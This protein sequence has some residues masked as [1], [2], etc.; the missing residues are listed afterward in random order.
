MGLI[1]ESSQHSE[2]SIVIATW[3]KIKL[4]EIGN[5]KCDRRII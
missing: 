1:N 3:Y 2:T 5:G 4:I